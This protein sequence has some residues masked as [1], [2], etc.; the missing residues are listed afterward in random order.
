[1][2]QQS[3]AKQSI[4]RHGQ[5][6]AWTVCE[7][8]LMFVVHMGFQVWFDSL[9]PYRVRG[10]LKFADSIFFP[11]RALAQGSLCV[12]FPSAGGGLLRT[13]RISARQR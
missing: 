10:C 7:Y 12:R 5:N 3:I 13:R 6:I 1:M 8:R 9:F 4:A 11:V 2:V